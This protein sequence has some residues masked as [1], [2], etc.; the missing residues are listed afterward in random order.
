MTR[1]R[2]LLR[3]LLLG[4]WLTTATAHAATP[5]VT[6]WGY[7]PM[8]D[9]AELRYEV[10]LPAGKGP[11][12]TLMNYEGY[13]AGNQPD[14]SVPD[15]AADALADGYAVVGVSLRG[16][17]CSDGTWQLFNRQQSEDGA[18]AV[19]WLAKQPWS[20]GRVDG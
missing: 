20:N 13:Q 5:A 16:S 10:W 14:D 11:F 8:A 7:I 2:K 3:L 6:K 12:P 4:L 15:L 9:G 1:A 18:A 17:G 19:D